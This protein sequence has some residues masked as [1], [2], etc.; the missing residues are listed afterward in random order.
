[1]SSRAEGSGR[2]LAAVTSYGRGAGSA[3][4]RV[5][6]WLDRLR[7]QADISDYTGSS[8]NSPT[9]LLKDAAGVARAESRL[10][11]LPRSVGASTLLLSRQASPFSNGQIERR[12]LEAA[13]RGVYDFDDALMHAP[14]G[15][16][17]LLWSKRRVWSRA[18]EAAD[19]V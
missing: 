1:M 8:S 7:I 13:E 10:R 18:A 3:R 12:L 14:R 5:F 17:D 11:R 15:A 19:L 6:D 16:L 4:V 9:V 2:R